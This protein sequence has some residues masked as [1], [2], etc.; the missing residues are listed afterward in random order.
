MRSPKP[1]R[2]ENPLGN[3]RRSAKAYLY[4]LPAFAVLAVFV[5]YPILMTLRMGFY[6]SYVY[7]TDTGTGFG[8][9]SFRYVLQD[10]AFGLAVRNT[11]FIVLVGV[12]ITIVLSL[13]AALLINS[14]LRTKG[15]FQTLYFL[16]YVTST[17]AIGLVFRWLFH[18][19]YGYINFFLEFLGLEPQK[20]LSDPNLTIVAVTI[21]TIWSGMAFK[22]V[23]FL[24]GLQKIDQQYYKAA[25]IDG[26][27]AHRIFFRITMPLL[28]PTFWM[29]TIVSVIHAFKTY[30]EVYAMFSRE[31]AGPGNSAIT[32]VYYIYDMFF[33]RG[34]VHYASAAA[35][36]FLAIVLALT[37]IQ[38]W[39]SKRYTMYK[40]GSDM[41]QNVGKAVKIA[42]LTV[43]AFVM[44][45][46]FLWMLFTSLKT[47][48]ESISIPPT[49][50][51]AVPQFE[52][53]TEALAVAPFGLY[54][55]NSIIVAG[56]GTLLTLVL[57]VL[58]AYGFTI[59]EFRGKKLLF[60][61]CLSTMM[62]PAEL[63]IIQNFI[64]ISKLGWMDTFQGI[65]LPTVAS[66]F[67][68]Y[69][70]REYFMQI[71][72]ILYKAAKVDGCSDWR[73]LW[74]V[75]IPMNKNAIATIG[76]LAFI[77]QWNSFVWPLMV[78]KSDAHRV[79][80]IGLLHFR[81]AVSS[82]VNLQMA[83]ATIVIVPMLIFFL[84]FRKQII[85]GVARGGIKG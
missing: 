57:T 35:I 28:S 63:L 12:P 22:I 54:L 29:V 34:Q 50:F 51:P 81:D 7:L 8:L 79:M 33:N 77:S 18:S 59:Y 2:A 24:A 66:G 6:Q 45:F 17:L 25:R 60:L 69:M 32:M 56:G 4:L 21:F 16:P 5:V 30:N 13:G 72:S 36:I 73:Y 10:P 42:V 82:Q 31:S 80:P 64:T 61:L 9:N 75:M 23:L 44:I 15:L 48:P 27:P 41:K 46:P 20:W 74:K 52:N 37:V 71:P 1:A 53:Y 47:L 58:S 62:I 14:L 39:V 3:T 84:V 68:I 26:T 78:T 76:I 65:I 85:A 11:M 83:G 43:G 70:M 55:R 40:G 19:E 49:L 38:K 67:Y